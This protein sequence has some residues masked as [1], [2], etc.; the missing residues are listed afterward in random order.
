MRHLVILGSSIGRDHL[1]L[2]RPNQDA[3]CALQGDWGAAAVV[4]DGCGSEPF[5]GVGARLGASMTAALAARQLEQGGPVD[6]ERLR[7]DILARLVI[8]AEAAAVSVREHLLFTIVG[9]A[10]SEQGASVFACGDGVAAVDGVVQVLCPFPDNQ[11]PYLTYALE[12]A[13]VGFTRIYEG[14]PR[15]G[16][17]PGGPPHPR[18]RPGRG[19]R[20]RRGPG[21]APAGAGVG[22]PDTAA[23]RGNPQGRRR[24]RGRG[25]PLLAR[26]HP[27]RVRRGPFPLRPN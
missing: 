4:C 15:P 23:L 18:P 6:L 24:G 22:R 21:L 25:F 26:V 16:R 7:A 2:E 14:P 8:V 17:R 1:L 12:G 3:C 5:S 9:A 20:L 13:R 19:L 27:R 11:P 10:L